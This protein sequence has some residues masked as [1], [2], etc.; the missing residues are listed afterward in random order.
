MTSQQ[1]P[2]CLH[3]PQCK[4]ETLPLLSAIT[5]AAAGFSG[6]GFRGSE[7]KHACFHHTSWKLVAIVSDFRTLF[8]L[9][10]KTDM[11]TLKTQWHGGGDRT[12]TVEPEGLSSVLKNRS[13]SVHLS[14]TNMNWPLDRPCAICWGCWTNRTWSFAAWEECW[15]HE[16]AVP[17]KCNKCWMGWE[18]RAR[19][20]AVWP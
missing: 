9:N 15:I 19:D 8:C 2:A 4:P 6:W 13:P 7:W 5:G 12:G 16:Q 10:A 17:R 18:P 20:L 1:F 11:F 14:L 3:Q